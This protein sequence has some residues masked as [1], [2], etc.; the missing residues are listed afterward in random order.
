M[1]L[2]AI[3]YVSLFKEIETKEV[4]MEVKNEKKAD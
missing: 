1:G 4:K 2:I 3:M